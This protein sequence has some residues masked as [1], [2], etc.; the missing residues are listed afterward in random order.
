MQ[1]KINSTIFREYDIRGTAGEDL[2]PEFAEYL[3]FAYAQFI[4][5]CKPVA[6]R[7]KLTVAVGKDCRL[8]S[9]SAERL[10]HLRLACRRALVWIFIRSGLDRNLRTFHMEAR[11]SII[12]KEQRIK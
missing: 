7:K 3:G 9:D 1:L 11:Y 8:S 10:D 12:Q 5:H 2:S 4:R 6:G